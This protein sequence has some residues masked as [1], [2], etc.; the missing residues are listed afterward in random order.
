MSGEAGANHKA[1]VYVHPPPSAFKH[2]SESDI[3]SYQPNTPPTFTQQFTYNTHRNSMVDNSPWGALGDRLNLKR[4]D[5]EEMAH[6]QSNHHLQRQ[7]TNTSNEMIDLPFAAQP[8]SKRVD[9]EL[10]PRHDIPRQVSASQRECPLTIQLEHFK[11]PLDVSQPTG[12][13][14]LNVVVTTNTVVEK[15]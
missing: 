13:V 7:D 5:L 8:G 2:N 12:P 4:S 11:G 3:E 1:A 10:Y 9:G 15:D 6:G 14:D